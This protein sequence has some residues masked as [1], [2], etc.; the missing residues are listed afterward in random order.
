MDG[1]PFTPAH[2]ALLRDPITHQVMA[3]DRVEMSVLLKLLA[4]QRRGL[5]ARRARQDTAECC[6]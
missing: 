5:L 6:A 1:E 4:D 2:E 3:S